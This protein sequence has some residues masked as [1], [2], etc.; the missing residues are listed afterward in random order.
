M[1]T[2]SGPLMQKYYQ[3]IRDTPILSRGAEHAL[4]E[5]ARGGDESARG[6]LIQSNLRFVVKMALNY[7][8][9]GLSLEDLVQEG[10][11]GLIEA[12]EKFDPERGCRLTTYASWWIRLALQRAVEQKSRQ[13]RIP[14]N[15]FESLRKLKAYRSRF[16]TRYGRTAT[17]EEAA[18]HLKLTV[19]NVD[20]L[21]ELDNQCLSLDT[22]L[23]E[24]HAA[25]DQFL[26][27]TDATDPGDTILAGEM[28]DCVDSLMEVLTEK[29]RLIINK[30][31]GL[32]DEG[33]KGLS[34]RQTGQI[35]GLSAEG[36]RRI[37]EQALRKLRHPSFRGRVMDL[38]PN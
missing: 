24:D 28:G 13:V 31:F 18:Q 9:S 30:R 19:D 26:A 11:L 12:V 36:V 32:G 25:A 29:E 14:I 1:N 35:V 37:E 17:S 23:D 10:N 22:P 20:D 16:L 33:S 15:K 7:R 8:N 38:L 4:A 27:D 5:R 3:D 21:D 2:Q 6:E 34:L